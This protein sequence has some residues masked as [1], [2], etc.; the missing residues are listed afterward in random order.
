MTPAEQRAW[1]ERIGALKHAGIGMPERV[2]LA[3]QQLAAEAA[4]RAE[5]EP[6]SP[7]T[8]VVRNNDSAAE[9]AAESDGPDATVD[10]AKAEPRPGGKGKGRRHESKRRKDA[11][12]KDFQTMSKAPVTTD[13]GRAEQPPAPSGGLLKPPAAAEF[14]AIGKRKLW[15]LTNARRIPCVRIDRS[16]RY[17]R[18]DLER[19]IEQHRQESIAG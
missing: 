16:V 6:P 13:A 5:P 2:E 17:R 14:L 19:W 9:P 1:D 4:A 11:K 7:S 12:G 18:D 3:K 10:E 15:E 8:P